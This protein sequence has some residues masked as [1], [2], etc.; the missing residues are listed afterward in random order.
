[1]KYFLNKVTEFNLSSYDEYVDINLMND[2]MDFLNYG[3]LK[4]TVMY[5]GKSVLFFLGQ[6]AGHLLLPFFQSQIFFFFPFYHVGGAE[7]VH[8]KIV[9]CVRDQKPLVFFTN[10][11]NNEAFKKMFDINAKNYEISSFCNKRIL[12]SLT[13]GFFSVIIN[14][15]KQITVFGCNNPFFYALLPYLNSHVHCFDLIHAF[16]NDSKNIIELPIVEK[17]DRR[18]VINSK[19]LQ[20]LKD[21]YESYGFDENVKERIILIENCISIPMVK[22]KVDNR[23]KLKILY[24]GR[25]TYEKRINLIGKFAYICHITNINIELA[26]VGDVMNSMDEK[27]RSYCYFFGEITDEIKLSEIY[28]DH[29]VLLLLSTSE[30]FPLVIMEAMAHGV[31]PISTDVGGIPDHVHHARNGFLIKNESEDM[32]LIKLTEIVHE[33]TIN[34]DLLKKLSHE[35]S[36]YAKVNF[37]CSNF[38]LN[39]YHLFSNEQSK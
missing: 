10:K 13:F 25:G 26:L 28:A 33:L 15:H 30:G 39:Y 4:R 17:L 37:N 12:R 35:A 20:D 19:T 3:S 5:S 31:V 32:I 11:S 9:A 36:E 29:D 2:I 27:Y 22:R 14:R 1:M 18:V 8:A 34:S 24:V 7:K 23:S 38:C 16:I 21:Q 6:I